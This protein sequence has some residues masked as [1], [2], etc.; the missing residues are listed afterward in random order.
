MGRI[1]I[2]IA[3]FAALVFSDAAVADEQLDSEGVK[4]CLE[5]NGTINKALGICTWTSQKGPP[6]DAEIAEE[7]AAWETVNRCIENQGTTDEIVESCT[8]TIEHG[9]LRMRTAAYFHR[10]NAWRAKKDYER[11]VADYGNAIRLNPDNVAA[12]YNRGNSYLDLGNW[13]QA[14]DSYDRAIEI[15]P[16]MPQFHSNRASAWLRKA[17]YGRAAEGYSNAIRVDPKEHRLYSNRGYAYFAMGLFDAAAKDFTYVRSVEPTNNYWW[18]WQYI[19]RGRA[20]YFK[21]GGEL[22]AAATQIDR[23]RWPGPIVDAALLKI[24]IEDLFKVAARLSDPADGFLCQTPFFI[25]ELGFANGVMTKEVKSALTD[26][27]NA[28]K[29]GSPEYIGAIT[30]LERL[31]IE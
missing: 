14:I 26:A 28:C 10:G 20:G 16:T 27:A 15:N 8:W 7:K 4:R 3:V 19:A 17:E 13:D 12:H 9:S 21:P 22:E 29:P 18:L 1:R 23:T 25:G 24:S 31:V 2:L 30:E 6:S 11:A 5:N